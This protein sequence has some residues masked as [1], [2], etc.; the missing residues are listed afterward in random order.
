M[1]K[2][3]AKDFAEIVFPAINEARF[4]VLY[5]ENGSRPNTPVNVIVGSLM[6]KEYFGLTEE[7]LLM[8]I[9]C[10]V[11]YQYALH[12]TQEEKPPV[13]DRT[14]S[15]FRER[16]LAYESKTGTDLMKAEMESLAKVMADHM[17]LRGEVKRMDSL[18][19][20]SRCKRMSRLE[21]IYTVNANAV[22]LLNRLGVTELLPQGC[23]HY[24]NEDDLNEVIYRC[25]GEEAESRLQRVIDEAVAL[26]KTLEDAGLTDKEEHE[27][28]SRVLEEQ[29]VPAEEKGKNRRSAKD[30][31][32]ISTDS[33]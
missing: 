27:L 19:V 24:L 16:L 11:Q 13:S 12:L 5:S 31:K 20:A 15:R 8:S 28:L 29:T 32:E 17:Q 2:S 3:W 25:R 18:M 4:S 26:K 30:K 33:L 14:W 1:D 6:L 10:N 7:E 23:S 9:Y 22:R 21:I